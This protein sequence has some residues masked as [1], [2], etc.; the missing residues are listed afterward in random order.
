MKAVLVTSTEGRGSLEIVD[1][2]AP[3]TRPDRILVRNFA[4]ALNRADILQ[5][6]GLYPPPEG[7]SGILGLEFAGEVAAAGEA[8]SGYRTGDRVFGLVGGGAYAEFL[9]VNPGLLLRIPD[10]LSFEAAAAVPE[11]FAT[12]LE[13]LFT[14]GGLEPGETVLVHAGASGV[15]CAAIQLATASGARVLATAGSPEK[16]AHCLELG[17]ARAVDYR[18]G[19]FSEEALGLTDGKGVDL[20]VDLVGAPH[21]DRNAKAI[22]IG[23]RWVLVGLLGGAKVLVDL[24][25]L[26]RK[27]VRLEGLL[28]RTRPLEQKIEGTRRFARDILPL[29]EDGRLRPVVDQVFLLEDVDEAH[30]RME[31]NRNIGKIVLRF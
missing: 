28:M 6:R 2:P 18:E 12:A 29:L 26:L 30:R 5:R 3:E 11:A 7:E 21:W 8:T 19:D 25:L 15:G 1:L 4:A 9:S 17:A 23:G 24:G 10:T 22:S 13:S 31:A 20:I 27:R 14:V 16:K